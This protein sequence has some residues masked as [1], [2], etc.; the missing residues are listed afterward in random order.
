M[1]IIALLFFVMIVGGCSSHS[2]YNAA[3]GDSIGYKEI[4]LA[5]NHYRVQF[6]VNGS[7]R[8]IAL[9]NVLLRSAELTV[10]QG[11]DWFVVENQKTQTFN[12]P[13]DFALTDRPTI[14]RN[15]DLLGC[16][17]STHLPEQSS[18]ISNTE[19][20]AMVEIRMGRGIRPEKESYDARGMWENQH[21]K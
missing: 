3:K 7:N 10:A 2:I 15:C 19:T 1:K 16:R 14:R 9:K 6:K 11:Y 21:I 12:E 18:D 4:A 17:N 20:V 13:D 8:S 5:S